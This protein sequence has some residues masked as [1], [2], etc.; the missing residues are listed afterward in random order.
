MIVCGKY[1]LSS[2]WQGHVEGKLIHLL[3]CYRETTVGHQGRQQRVNVLGL[4]RGNV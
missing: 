1:I 4:H 2:N 3:L